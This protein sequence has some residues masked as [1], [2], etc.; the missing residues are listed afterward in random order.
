MWRLKQLRHVGSVAAAHGL[1]CSEA[2]SSWSRDGTGAPCTGSW[3]LSHYATRDAS[4][5]GFNESVSKKAQGM[6]ASPR[7][8]PELPGLTGTRQ[9]VGCPGLAL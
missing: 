3:I 6:G 7:S 4:H 5:Q 8:V 9:P 1:N 2:W